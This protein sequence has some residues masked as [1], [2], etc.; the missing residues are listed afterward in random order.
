MYAIRSFVVA[1]TL[2]LLSSGAL[3]LPAALAQTELVMIE[4]DGCPYC[5]RWNEEI[6]PIYPKTP[7]G[8]RAP[9]VRHNIR[10]D[11]PDG[12]QLDRRVVFTP[13][14]ILLQDGHEVDR[15]EG[16][17][18]QDFF[19]GLLDRMLTRLDNSNKPEE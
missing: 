11:L 17:P 7:E 18:G 8:A 3:F 13:T 16:Y 12:M 6:G 2:A 15:L 1:G 10:D 9:L 19:W 14:F 5:A 4:R